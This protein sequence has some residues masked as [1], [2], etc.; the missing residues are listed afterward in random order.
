MQSHI[1]CII[2]LETTHNSPKAF[3]PSFRSSLNIFHSIPFL[4]MIQISGRVVYFLNVIQILRHNRGIAAERL[5]PT[6][7]FHRSKFYE[8]FTIILV[9][10]FNFASICK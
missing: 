10:W 7:L 9:T 3:S 5:M 1:K 8:Y 4:P 2:L 6:F